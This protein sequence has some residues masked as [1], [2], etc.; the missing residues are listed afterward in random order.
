HREYKSPK[1]LRRTVYFGLITGWCAL[2]AVAHLHFWRNLFPAGLGAELVSTVLVERV[3]RRRAASRE[4][5]ASSWI[6]LT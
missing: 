4:R 3:W 2:T 6:G 5:E 1:W